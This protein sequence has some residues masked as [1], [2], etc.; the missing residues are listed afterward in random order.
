MKIE[1][2][3]QEFE[4]HFNNLCTFRDVVFEQW[5]R[6][7]MSDDSPLLPLF[8]TLSFIIAYLNNSED[9]TTEGARII[10]IDGYNDECTF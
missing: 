9:D 8:E 3:P 4:Y 2:D 7:E 1:Y 10:P 6:D 5:K